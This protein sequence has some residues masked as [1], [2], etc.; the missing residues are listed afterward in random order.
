MLSFVL[1]LLVMYVPF[2]QSVFTTVPLRLADWLA[3]SPFFLMASIA[4]EITKV[5]LR[6]RMESKEALQARA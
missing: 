6:R 2:L 5:I 1:L 3:M 4:A